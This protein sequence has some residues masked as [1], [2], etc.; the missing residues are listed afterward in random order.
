MAHNDTIAAVVSHEMRIAG[1]TTDL[2]VLEE[3]M[4]ATTA[5]AA[6]V[7]SSLTKNSP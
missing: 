1:L 3:V 4:M 2:F 7:R 6:W 5:R